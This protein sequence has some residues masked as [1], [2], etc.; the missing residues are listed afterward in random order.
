MVV[1]TALLKNRFFEKCL[2][3]T[4]SGLQILIK[5]TAEKSDLW[6]AICHLVEESTKQILFVGKIWI[7]AEKKVLSIKKGFKLNYYE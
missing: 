2:N 5:L 7:F 1:K 4:I 6:F 3:Y